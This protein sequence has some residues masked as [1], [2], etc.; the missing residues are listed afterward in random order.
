MKKGIKIALIFIVGLTVIVGDILAC[1]QFKYLKCE[2]EY[3][4]FKDN[5]LGKTSVEIEEIYGNFDNSGMRRGEDG[6]FRST[7]CSYVVI[8]ERVGFFGTTP[9]YVISIGFDSNGIA[10]SVCFEKGGF[11]G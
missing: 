1:W 2:K 8:E 3:L 7:R 5:V 10:C 4:E 9:P 6:L 11:G